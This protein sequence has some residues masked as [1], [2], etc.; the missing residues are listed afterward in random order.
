[1]FGNNISFIQ[2]AGKGVQLPKR[3]SWLCGSNDFSLPFYKLYLL[4][5][6]LLEKN[7]RKLNIWWKNGR[8]SIFCYS[9][10]KFH[11]TDRQKLINYQIVKG[12]CIIIM[13]PPLVLTV[14][15]LKINTQL[16]RLS[17]DWEWYQQEVLKLNSFTWQRLHL[18]SLN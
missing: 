5:F 16:Y 4:V 1:M 3:S 12:Q 18:A 13:L 14:N 8:G 9:H 17:E 10:A 7:G 2:N 11:F 15:P 6:S